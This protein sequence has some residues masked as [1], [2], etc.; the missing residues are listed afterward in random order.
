LEARVACSR[1]FL[2]N[3]HHFDAD[4]LTHDLLS[5]EHTQPDDLIADLV[6]HNC[7]ADVLSF[8]QQS[9]D[10]SHNIL[11]HDHKKPNNNLSHCRF[12]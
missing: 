11:S 12:V 7:S 2:Q 5:H 1:F 9:N 10:L 8:N 6:A 3:L 4:L